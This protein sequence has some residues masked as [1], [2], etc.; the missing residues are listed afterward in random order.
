VSPLVLLCLRD[1]W[2]GA[3]APAVTDSQAR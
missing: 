3:F 2:V 1:A